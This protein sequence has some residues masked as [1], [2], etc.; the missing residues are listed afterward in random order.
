MAARIRSKGL[1]PG[2]CLALGLWHAGAATATESWYRWVDREGVVH[3]EREAPGLGIAYEPV[4]VPDSITWADRPAIPAQLPA[5]A[6]RSAADALLKAPQ[7]VYP[8]F[9]GDRELPRPLG[10]AVAVSETA[11]LTTCRVAQA[12]GTALAIGLYTEKKLVKAELVAREFLSDRCVIAVRDVRLRP[13]AGVRRL[14]TLAAGE[15][16]FA[17]GNDVADDLPSSECVFSKVQNLERGRFLRISAPMSPG[18]PGGGLFD[19]RGNLVGITTMEQL[20]DPDNGDLA[21]P[22]ADF[23]LQP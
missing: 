3:L 1:L 10:A 9:G 14:E 17:I 23:W 2:V 16:V 22:A 15:V 18:S 20:W 11:L 8:V 12:A 13:V 21:V 7:S 5:T 19:G 6:D 4:L